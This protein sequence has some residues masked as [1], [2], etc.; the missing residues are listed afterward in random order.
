MAVTRP[1]FLYGTLRYLPLL[2]LVA[3]AELT[4]QDALLSGYS[5]HRVDGADFPRIVKGGGQTSGIL[6]TD[7]ES[8]ARLDYYEGG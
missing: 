5:V 8:R 6:V 1:L 7:A 4:Y 2:K 3:G